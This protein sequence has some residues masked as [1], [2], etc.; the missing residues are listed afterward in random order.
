MSIIPLTMIVLVCSP[1]G[2]VP[3]ASADKIL[4]QFVNLQPCVPSLTYGSN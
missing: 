3:Y 1:I 2:I 4:M